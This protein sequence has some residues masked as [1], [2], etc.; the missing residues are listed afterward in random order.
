M[1]PSVAQRTPRRR[2]RHGI[3]FIFDGAALLGFAGAIHS[4]PK[5]DVRAARRLCDGSN[6]C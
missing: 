5:A 1:P 4:L 6:G 2:L 3:D